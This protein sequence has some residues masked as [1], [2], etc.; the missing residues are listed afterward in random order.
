MDAEH[1]LSVQHHMK[2]PTETEIGRQSCSID[3]SAKILKQ[4]LVSY[5]L[6][7]PKSIFPKIIKYTKSSLPTSLNW[8]IATCLTCPV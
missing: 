2:T 6:N 3:P 7:W 4:I 5:L 8:A 1:P